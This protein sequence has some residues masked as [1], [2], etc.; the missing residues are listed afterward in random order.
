MLEGVLLVDARVSRLAVPQVLGAEPDAQVLERGAA[1]RQVDELVLT[2]PV[3]DGAA[4]EGEAEDDR[5]GDGGAVG[6]ERREDLRGEAWRGV[7]MVFQTIYYMLYD[8]LLETM[9]TQRCTCLVQEDE[10][11]D[12]LEQK[13]PNHG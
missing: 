4:G 5:Y 11:D 12:R 7:D 3:Q 6:E 1:H 9:N 13:V 10:R 8:V 2:R